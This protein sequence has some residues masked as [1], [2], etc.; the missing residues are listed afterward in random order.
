LEIPDNLDNRLAEWLRGL[1]TILRLQAPALLILG[2]ETVEGTIVH[3]SAN[4]QGGYEV[5]MEIETLL[6]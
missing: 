2:N 6:K 3:Y 1:E 4:V 5:T